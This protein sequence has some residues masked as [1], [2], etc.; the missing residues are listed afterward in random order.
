MQDGRGRHGKR[1]CS[2]IFCK[3]TREGQHQHH[4]LLCKDEK[5]QSDEQWNC[6]KGNVGQTS[7]R[8]DGAHMGFSERVD[9]IL[10]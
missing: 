10:N 1:K 9:T 2:T 3:K 8:P 7:E 5:H 4:Y 6:F